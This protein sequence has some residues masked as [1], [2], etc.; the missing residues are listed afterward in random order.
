[1][2]SRTTVCFIFR[3]TEKA[4]QDIG[5][6]EVFEFFETLSAQLSRQFNWI[7]MADPRLPNRS[8]ARAECGCLARLSGG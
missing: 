6:A 4:R 3:G 7:E 5:K 1:M 8:R 2:R